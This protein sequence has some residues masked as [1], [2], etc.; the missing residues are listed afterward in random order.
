VPPV[1]AR[2]AHQS[3]RPLGVWER[4]RMRLSARRR[5]RE[6][7]EDLALVREARAEMAAGAE[8]IP[9]EQVKVEHD[10]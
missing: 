8:P 9:W 5:A 2:A 1:I 7:A 4:L 6:D 10:L 3:D